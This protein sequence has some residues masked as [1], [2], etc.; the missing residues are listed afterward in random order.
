MELNDA[1]VQVGDEQWKKG[2]EVRLLK[3]EEDED[4][5]K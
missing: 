3:E 2:R 1:V 4:E 5:V